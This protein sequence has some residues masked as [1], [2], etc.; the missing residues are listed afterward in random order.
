MTCICTSANINGIQSCIN[1]I[2]STAPTADV[3]SEGQSVINCELTSQFLYIFCPI[4][5]VLW[6]TAFNQECAGQG[7]AS[8]TFGSA[9]GSSATAAGSSASATS[10]NSKSAA[11]QVGVSMAG[12]I[13]AG[14]LGSL[15]AVF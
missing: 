7:V 9:G 1:C 2:V 14:I 12:F 6:T 4:P 13:G 15:V 8:L 5:D 3:V 11:G 10:A